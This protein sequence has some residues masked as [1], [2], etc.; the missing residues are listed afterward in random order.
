M[1]PTAP[2]HLPEQNEQRVEKILK[3]VISIYDRFIPIHNVFLDRD[4]TKQLHADHSVNEKDHGDQ[5]CNVRQRLK[6]TKR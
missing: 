6:Q 2:N 1:F 3:I 5:Q 4:L